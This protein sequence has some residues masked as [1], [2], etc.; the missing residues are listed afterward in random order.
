MKAENLKTK[1]RRWVLVLIFL[2]IFPWGLFFSLP[3][4]LIVPPEN[5]PADAI[6]H[7]I[8]DPH[9][10][11]NEYVLAL[12]KK[13]LAK[14]I[15]C[16]STP[17][18]W[19]V[20]PSDYVARKLVAEGVRRE[21][22]YVLRNPDP[23]E[24][25]AQDLPLLTRYAQKRGWKRV[26]L[27]VNPAESRFNRLIAR[28]YFRHK[29]IQVFVTYSPEDYQNI[30]DHWWSTHWKVQTFVSSA[31]NTLLDQIYPQCR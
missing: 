8:Y 18:A 20:Y 15:L 10:K 13:G 31:V 29:G 27:V 2:A 11:A 16:S 1:R 24:C 5:H 19:N 4:L 26:L 25:W 3:R 30:L 17:V 23:N 12:Y 21:D 9:S 28:K 6:I 14:K 7:L 22:V